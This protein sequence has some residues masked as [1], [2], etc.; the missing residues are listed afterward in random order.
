VYALLAISSGAKNPPGLV[1]DYTES[2]TSERLYRRVSVEMLE[3]FNSLVYLLRLICR[4]PLSART[5]VPSWCAV[6]DA[7]VRYNPPK[8]PPNVWA[9]HPRSDISSRPVLRENQS[10]LAIKGKIFD[11]IAVTVFT[12]WNLKS[13]Y[14]RTNFK[15]EVDRYWAQNISNIADILSRQMTVANAAHLSRTFTPRAKWSP[16]SRKP[17]SAMQN[18]AFHLWAFCLTKIHG[19]DKESIADPSVAENFHRCQSFLQNLKRLLVSDVPFN[20]KVDQH[21]DEE[22]AIY[23]KKLEYDILCTLGLN[24]D[25]IQQAN[26]SMMKHGTIEDRSLGTTI[27]GRYVNAI[28]DIEEGDAIAAFQGTDRLWILRPTRNN[29]YRLVTEAYVDGLMLGEGYPTDRD[30][31]EEDDDEILI[32]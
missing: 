10:I 6:L 12:P 28:H 15:E 19:I 32:V 7:L 17:L 13:S 18:W 1:P 20:T 22:N 21:L 8:S 3:N 9:P 24:W 14:G 5:N 31:E 30:Y 4:V 26:E 2:N 23:G 27:E 25:D 16:Q 29:T 11:H